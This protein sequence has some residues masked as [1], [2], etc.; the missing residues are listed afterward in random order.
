[1]YTQPILTIFLL[2]RHAFAIQY[3]SPFVPLIPEGLAPRQEYYCAADEMQ[4]PDG[5]CCPLDAPCAT[6][7]GR[8]VCDAICYGP[9]CGDGTCCD[10]GYACP[11]PGE[12]FCTPIASFSFPPTPPPLS[13]QFTT[14]DPEE[15]AVPSPEP[16]WNTPG[17]P[18]SWDTP[19]ATSS[20]VWSSTYAASPTPTWD[21][22]ATSE[23]F[24]APSTPTMSMSTGSQVRSSWMGWVFA[25]AALP[26]VG[27]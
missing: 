22:G 16:S 26:F 14:F 5:G 27:L 7:M 13:V 11:P 8:P 25:V 21:S 3:I 18:G 20:W 6:Q 4:C 12:R 23:A 15:T 10:I 19:E 9:D 2:C 24:P 1:M 17:E